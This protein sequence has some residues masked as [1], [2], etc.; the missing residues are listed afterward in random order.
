MTEAVR[1][2]AARVA[3]SPAGLACALLTIAIAVGSGWGLPGSDSW[4]ADSISPRSCGLGAIAET[5]LP[6]HFHTYPPLQMGL[7]TVLAVPWFVVAGLRVGANLDRLTAQLIEPAPMTSIEVGSRMITAAMALGVVL[8]AARLW[9]RLAGPIAARVAGIVTALDATLVYYAHTGNLDVPS[10]FWV[11]GTL[12]EID[13][14][15]CGEPREARA[16]LWAVAA[17]L[18]KDQAAAALL[19][20]LVL[21]LGI[22][23]AHF[24]GDAWL[25]PRL[26]RGVLVALCVF[27]LASG[28]VTNPVGFARRVAFLIG[29]ASQSWAGYPPGWRGAL[30]LAHDALGSVS[31]FTSWPVAL[32]AAAGVAMGA[33]EP[34][35]L[36]RARLMLPFAAAV[37]FTLFFTLGARRS[38]DRFL[39]PHALLL[40]PYAALFARAIWERSA[41]R[42]R[43]R[44][45]LALAGAVALGPA[46][47]GVVSVDATLLADPRYEVERFLAALPAGTN[48][49][50]I[51]GPIFLP[52]IPRSLSAVRPGIEPPSERQAIPGVT[53]L[54]DPA[55]DPRP[56]AP[57][58][59]VVA[60]DLS[61]VH[62]T[63][64]PPT[65]RAFALAQYGDAK[66]HALLRGLYDGSFGY[67]RALRARCEL[68]WPL[69][70]RRIHA[71]TGGE[72]WVYARAP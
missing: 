4:A 58:V 38:E 39:L 7:L 46:A 32:A 24:R 49:E 50:L 3:G 16:L 59:I 54:V 21:G 1:R 35:P 71:S 43:A 17:A 64:P 47:V 12:V 42:P 52:R 22:V 23:P 25:R 67:R 57:E 10:L 5:Y 70:C 36:R 33:A 69:E 55:L 53:D 34:E 44:L 48:I 2:L 27:A 30:S 13:R 28:A 62:S 15:M 66:S 45:A 63:E 60:A 72:V 61:N 14:V 68:P 65:R 51:G 26:M 9:G 56:R 40:T 11:T 20:P 41:G 6:G 8:L 19:L 37:S 18:T 29:P 31:H